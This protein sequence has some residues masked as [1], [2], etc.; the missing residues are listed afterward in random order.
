MRTPPWELP[1]CLHS[2]GRCSAPADA[3]SGRPLS[4]RTVLLSLLGFFGIV[5]AAN[6]ALVA[7]AIGTMP[8]LETEKPYQAGIGYNAEIAVARAQAG[9]GWRL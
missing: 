6:G 8:G 9:R 2:S 3:A 7:F 4:G 5:I 1:R